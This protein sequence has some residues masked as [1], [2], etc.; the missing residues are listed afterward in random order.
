MENEIAVHRS[1]TVTAALRGGR[2]FGDARPCHLRRGGRRRGSR[3]S[4]F[5]SEVSREHGEPL[6][7]TASRVDRW[8]L[9]EYHGAWGRDAVDSSA[10]SAE[11]KAHLVRRADALRPVKVLVHPPP[12]AARSGRHPCLLGKLGA[13]RSVARVGRRRG[14]TRTCSTSNSPT[15]GQPLTASAA[16]RLHAREA[17]RLL[18]E[19]RPAGLRGDARVS[20]TKGG[21]GSAR[22][23]A[24]TASRA[25]S[26]ACPRASTTD[27]SA[28]AT[29]WRCSRSTSPGA[30]TLDSLP[31]TFLL[32][33]SAS[34]P[35]SARSATRRARSASTISSFVSTSPIV[36]RAGGTEY[37]VDVSV[38]DGDLSQLT[39]NAVGLSRP[40]R[41][42]ARILRESAA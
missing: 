8:I 33:R 12:R 11:V 26:S 42:V 1:G 35:Q 14:A 31:R 30:C 2:R 29:S 34:R 32:L 18:R 27:A 13:A 5:C 10:L 40:R 3:D 15:A 25:T 9:I 28:P 19:V 21:S 39:C 6:A 41:Y 16:A 38:E 4:R 20:S 23:W 37:E 22:T 36:F 17:R 7:A 24:A